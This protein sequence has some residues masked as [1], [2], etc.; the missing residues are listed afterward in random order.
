MKG[1]FVIISSPTGG[2]KDAVIKK[3]TEIFPN[4]TRLVTTTTRSPR[5]T[6]QEGVTYNFISK[7]EFEN[8]IKEKY[9]LE[10]NDCVGNYYGTPREKLEKLLSEN[11]LVFSNA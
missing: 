8:K 11:E 10:Y 4:S 5:P 6:D 9:F 2:G 1:I 3:L 7:Q